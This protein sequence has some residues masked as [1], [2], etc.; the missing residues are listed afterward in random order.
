MAA[1][2]ITVEGRELAVKVALTAPEGTGAS[3]SS[4]STTDNKDAT[5]TDAPK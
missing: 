2:K 4:S 5:K 3:S 1:E